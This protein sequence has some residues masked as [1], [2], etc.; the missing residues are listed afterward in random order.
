M[1]GV[2]LYID[3]RFGNVGI[4]TKYPISHLDIIGDSRITDLYVSE[5]IYANT[6]V[7]DGSQLSGISGGTSPWITNGASNIYYSGN[8]GIGSA[9]NARFRMID[10][11]TFSG[12]ILPGLSNTYDLG[13][14]NLRW[15]KL[16]LMGNT[17]KLD[18]TRISKD[19]V[20]GGMKVITQSGQL[21]PLLVGNLGIGT[22]LPTKTVDING[23]I[24]INGNVGIGTA[25]PK[26]SLDVIGTIKA[27]KFVGNGS[28]LTNIP[29]GGG[30]PIWTTVGSNI[31]YSTSGNVGIGTTNPQYKLHI[32]G[33][34]NALVEGEISARSF[35]PQYI[36]KQVHKMFTIDGYLD[37]STAGN[38]GA[39]GFNGC[40][41]DGRYIY[42]VPHSNAYSNNNYPHGIL[43]RIDIAKFPST[44]AVS[45]LDV[46]SGNSEA[47][48]FSGGFT[49]GRYA[50]LVPYANGISGTHGILT[51]IDLQN[52]TSGG[53]TY[54]DVRGAGNTDA[55][56]FKGGFTDGSYAYLVPYFM[57][58]SIL[59][60]V[61]LNDFTT[62]GITYLDVST[63]NGG[64]K[65]FW[66]GFTDGRYG[67][68]VPYNNGGWSS[69]LTRIDLL[70]FTA[71][72]ITYLD[73]SSGNNAGRGFR[74]GFTDGRYAYLVP[75]FNDYGYHGTITRVDLQTFSTAGLSYLNLAS[76]GNTGAKG[77][78]GGFTDGRYVYFV[79]E[80][81]DTIT[82]H[83]I[84]TRVDIYNFTAS[85]VS[86]LDVSVG[87]SGAKG[88]YGGIVNNSYAYL[89]PNNNNPFNLNVSSGVLTR[90]NIGNIYPQGF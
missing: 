19:I 28:G 84:L 90:I 77:F 61:N 8:V 83:A 65:G 4:G 78:N 20:N 88:F 5:T 80:Y 50:Y 7:G 58:N 32:G 6:F 22:T 59:V 87:N 42:L 16:Y 13:S 15:N 21:S 52:F 55:K 85:G 69:I 60:R 57:A 73:V 41:T 26:T 54:L 89:A 3:T 11:S 71:G 31:Y 86:Y 75:N 67:Y 12:N 2:G 70:N 17:I 66:G 34:S 48:G 39:K 36:L 37:V 62:T 30:T 82:Y 38:S 49:D 81:N 23:N 14:S 25:I 56:G 1:T 79:P 33:Y 64:A 68:L 76:A 40:F 43:T 72:G 51:R 9:P 29:T 44:T 45:Y 10:T 24:F 35:R 63:G 18:G 27:K 74:G 53:I 47:T 46:S